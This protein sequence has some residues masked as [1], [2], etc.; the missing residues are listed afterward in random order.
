MMSILFEKITVIVETVL[1]STQ[2]C[3][4]YA[5]NVVFNIYT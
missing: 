2:Q 5:H 3:R 1:Q 4:L